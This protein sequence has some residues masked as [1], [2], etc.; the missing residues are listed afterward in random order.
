MQVREEFISLS[1]E[2][3]QMTFSQAAKIIILIECIND[4]Q[5][6][7]LNIK[8]YSIQL[9]SVVRYRGMAQVL[10]D[11]SIFVRLVLINADYAKAD[12]E[13]VSKCSFPTYL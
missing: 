3:I 11:K 4:I 12:T 9:S 13:R 1:A 2:I 6:I 8:N 10:R 7:I 5:Y